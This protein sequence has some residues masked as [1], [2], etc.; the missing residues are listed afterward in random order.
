[1]SAQ[2]YRLM[3]SGLMGNVYI[4]K[5]TANPHVM[6]SDRRLVPVDEL[7]DTI[8]QHTIAKLKPGCNTLEIT[9]E[10]GKPLV[11]IVVKDE[12][13]LKSAKPPKPMPKAEPAKKK[14]PAVKT[15]KDVAMKLA[16]GNS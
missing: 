8:I 4:G 16:R 12:T 6:S 1:M 9:N 7:Y 14:S 3:V 13:L 5:T 11:E 10:H 2:K 15:A